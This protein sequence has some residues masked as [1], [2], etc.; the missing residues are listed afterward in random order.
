MKSLTKVKIVTDSTIDI[1]QSIIEEWNIEIVPL[2]IT[3][4]GQSYIDRFGITPEEFMDKMK[5]SAEL[6]KAL[7]LRWVILLIPT[8]D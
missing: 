4:D 2:S 3:I 1:E 5:H 6:P 7:S 8:I